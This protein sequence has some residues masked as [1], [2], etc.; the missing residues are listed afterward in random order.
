MALLPADEVDATA[1]LFRFLLPVVALSGVLR[2]GVASDA[3]EIF[4]LRNH[5]H[6]VCY[7]HTMQY[8]KGT[9]Q[10]K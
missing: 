2:P 9:N 10:S 6:Y 1:I 5:T 4:N 8:E 3:E 7:P